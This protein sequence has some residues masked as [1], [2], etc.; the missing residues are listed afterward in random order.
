MLV[1]HIKFGSN[2][3]KVIAVCSPY[4]IYIGIVFSLC[5]NSF[6][7]VFDSFLARGIF[8]NMK[9]NAESLI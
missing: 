2:R 6:C 1:I 4:I 5:A 8:T 9:N 7:N 3:S